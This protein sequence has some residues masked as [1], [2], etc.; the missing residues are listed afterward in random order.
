MLDTIVLEHYQR[1]T[2]EDVVYEEQGNSYRCPAGKELT[3]K[4][5][6]KLNRNSG[7]KYRAKSSDCKDCPLRQRCIAGGGE[8]R[9][10]KMR[11]KITEV[12]YRT[13]YGKRMQIIE[14]CFF[15]M[16]TARGWTGFH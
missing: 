4:G 1:F 15:N 2:V 6:V 14:P 3:Y 5:Q 16:V 8:N 12:K 7:E 9:C 10:E 11:K 13:V